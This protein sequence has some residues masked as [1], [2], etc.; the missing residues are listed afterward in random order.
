MNCENAKKLIG[1]LADGELDPASAT[2]VETHIATCEGCRRE[3][4]ALQA[5]RVATANAPPYLGSQGLADRARAKYSGRGSRRGARAQPI[6]FGLGAAA[7]SLAWF[8]SLRAFPPPSRG[9]EE[10]VA[11][12]VRSLMPGH[13]VD[14]ASTDRHTVKPWFQGKVSVVPEP[15]DLTQEGFPLIGGR[16]DYIDS[17]PTPVLVTACASTLST[18]L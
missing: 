11:S 16:L 14:V 15:W 9:E 13:L 1:A 12:H 4:R 6:W 18:F 10:I 2:E 7:A 17:R 8:V 5:L 3:Q